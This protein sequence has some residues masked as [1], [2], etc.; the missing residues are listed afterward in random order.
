MSTH[1]IR[2]RWRTA[3]FHG[4]AAAGLSACGAAP[5]PFEDPTPPCKLGAVPQLQLPSSLAEG[6]PPLRDGSSAALGIEGHPLAVAGPGGSQL[7]AVDPWNGTLVVL[8]KA[9]LATLKTFPVGVRASKLVAVGQEAWVAASGGSEI[10]RINTASGQST[11]WQVGPEPMGLALTADH[12]HLLVAVAGT[13]ELQMRDAQTGALLAALP[14][15]ARPMA[16]AVSGEQVA[17][18]TQ[19]SGV[20]LFRLHAG[21]LTPESV[22]PLSTASLVPH[23]S[24]LLN[25]QVESSPAKSPTAVATSQG[26]VNPTR[27]V[28]IAASPSGSGFAVAHV[29]ARPGSADTSLAAHQVTMVCDGVDTDGAPAAAVGGYGGAGD[30][31]PGCDRPSPRA[32]EAAISRVG[33]SQALAD[34]SVPV[35]YGGEALAARLDQPDDIA[36]DPQRALMYLVGRGSDDVLVVRD[37][38]VQQALGIIRLPTGS[39]PTGIATDGTKAWVLGANQFRITEVALEPLH[40]RQPGQPA[41]E[42]DLRAASPKLGRHSPAFAKDPLPAAAREGRAIFFNA[43]N[44]ALSA[45]H[46]FACA[47]CHVNGAEDQQT[48][49]VAGGPRQTPSLAGRLAGTFPYNWKGTEVA[50]EDNM[51]DTVHRMGGKGLSPSSLASLEQ[52]LLVGLQALPSRPA[53]DAAA[54]ADGRKAFV[55]AGCD[56]CHTKGTGSDGQLHNGGIVNDV[57][58]QVASLLGLPVSEGLLFNTPSLRSVGVT[59]PYFHDGRFATLEE[60]LAATSDQGK[61]GDTRGLTAS[62]RANLM[63][64]LRSL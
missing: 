43:H 28:A 33:G 40:Q 35:S 14:T 3:L 53:T 61:M 47:T 44:N 9:S 56:G 25:G 55:K 57:D 20:A 2:H 48:W 26:A 39:A 36:F 62:E 6:A 8:D 11:T 34:A 59:A 38:D 51:K 15:P 19:S 49:F 12:H 27:A 29:V 13:S 17:V 31:V 42:I 50:L 52:F 10:V 41:N 21:K 45:N 63:T 37:N 64:Y 7:F 32:I 16:V 5:D 24:A 54:L 46:A 18:A 58:V 4:F 1:V 60:A 22:A 30:L 23:C